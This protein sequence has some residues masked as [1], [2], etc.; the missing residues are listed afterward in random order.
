LHR[1]ATGSAGFDD[2]ELE[3]DSALEDDWGDTSSAHEVTSTGGESEEAQ[4]LSQDELAKMYERQ[5]HGVDDQEAE[6][7]EDLVERMQLGPDA[8]PNS[9]VDWEKEM[10][11]FASTRP[12]KVK[13]FE[14]V[15]G[16]MEQSKWTNV[17][18]NDTWEVQ[19]AQVPGGMTRTVLSGQVVDEKERLLELARGDTVWP[20]ATILSRWLTIGPPVVSL[21]G[22][23]VIELGAG[24]GLPSIVAGRMGAEHLLVQDKLPEPLEQVMETAVR[25]ALADRATTLRCRWSDLAAR[26]SDGR[27]QVLRHFEAAD[28][29]LGSDI[30]YTQE[31]AFEVAD[32]LGDFFRQD[33]QVA[34]IVDPFTRRHRGD[35]KER[36]RSRGLHVDDME[37]VTWEPDWDDRMEVSADWACRLLTVRRTP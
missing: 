4:D 36:C 32:F 8:I 5:K 9:D 34:Y 20:A 22:K 1:Q 30:L 15:G 23:A 35:F 37:I 7:L 31:N 27:E 2:F 26:I 25:E 14:G 10:A 17:F 19:I 11:E 3:M 33:G 28:V 6:F 29:V 18:L 13:G 21:L 12:D 24:C 16:S